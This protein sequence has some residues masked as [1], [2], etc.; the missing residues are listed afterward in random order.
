MTPIVDGVVNL[1]RTL[2]MVPGAVQPPR[3][4][5]RCFDGSVNALAAESGIFRQVPWMARRSGYSVAGLH[6][7]DDTPSDAGSAEVIGWRRR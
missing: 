4:D 3:I 5:T 2:R 1:L 7:V 6:V